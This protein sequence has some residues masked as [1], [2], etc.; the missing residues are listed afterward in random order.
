MN[1]RIPPVARQELP[2]TGVVYPQISVHFANGARMNEL[3]QQIAR[4][5][6]HLVVE[7]FLAHAV[8]TLF[9]ALVAAAIAIAVPRLVSIADLPARWDVICLTLALVV[10]VTSAVV[11]TALTRRSALD[12][13]IE[14][15]RRF[16]LRERVASTLSL[17]EA[18]QQTEAGHALVKDAQRAASRIDIGD[19]FRLRLSKRAALPLVPAALAFLLILF[20]N[21]TNATSSHDPNSAAVV[22]KPINTAAEAARKKLVE[23]RKE[24]ERSGL[25]NAEDIFKKIEAGVN[26]LAKKKDVDRTKAAVE[27]N[28]LAQQLQ[29]RRKQLGGK[30]GLQKQLQNLKAL[31]H[32]PAEKAAQAMKQGDFKQAAEELN[33]L[34]EQLKSG[35]LD[36][37]AK[38]QLA[39]QLEAMKQ[40]LADAAAAQEQAKANLEK[41]IADARAAG[42]LAKAGELQEKLDQLD[43]Q[44]SAM[45]Q[46]QQLSNQMAGAQKS[47]QQG[48][49][50]QAAKAMQQMAQQLGQMQQDANE[51]EMLDAA[52]GDLQLAKDAMACQE[53]SGA[54]C[55]S[56]QGAGS[57]ASQGEGEG[58]G[59]GS[60]SESPG[61]RVNASVKQPGGKPGNGIGKGR[62][63]ASSDDPLNPATNNQQARQQPRQGPAVYAGTIAGP[64]IKGQV[65]ATIQQDMA[66]FSGASSDPLTTERLPR[67]RR[68]HAEEYFNSLR[69]GK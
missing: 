12:A 53:C 30:A 63:N 15:D 35:K 17:S 24:A 21:P 48:D 68:E 7:Q 36:D 13:A 25:K 11:W 44:S 64:N 57:M 18:E 16:D 67:N 47:L 43:S 14:I 66:S 19:K 49:P 38:A 8:W 28:N 26:E 29:E 10:G 62:G 1:G 60:A 37:T 6:R 45:K 9:G 4:A 31:G 20:F 3:R 34:A 5:R 41:Q 2:A 23:K 22:A 65:Q 61:K 56:C 39:K 55:E 50:S 33:K 40:Q 46:L 42:D 69:D 27:L 52:E 54:G 58:E 32:G 59:A 51:A